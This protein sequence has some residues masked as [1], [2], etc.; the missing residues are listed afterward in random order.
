MQGGSL[1]LPVVLPG[2]TRV[3]ESR[4]DQGT[5]RTN[6]D[7]PPSI[8]DMGHPGECKASALVGLGGELNPRVVSVYEHRGRDYPLRSSGT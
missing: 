7:V 8:G 3:S 2:G 4:S 1:H 6:R 5:R